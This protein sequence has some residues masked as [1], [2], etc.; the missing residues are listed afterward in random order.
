MNE[1]MKNTKDF[2][3]KVIQEDKIKTYFYPGDAEWYMGTVLDIAMLLNKYV[4]IRNPTQ[5]HINTYGELRCEK[6]GI[7]KTE[8][9]IKEE[10]ENRFFELVNKEVIVPVM[11][12]ED[13]GIMAA[14]EKLQAELNTVFDPEENLFHKKIEDSK[15][16]LD[17][18][19]F[20]INPFYRSYDD[21]MKI[22]KDLVNS[23]AKDPKFKEII[24][25]KGY[26]DPSKEKLIS[27]KT[28]HDPITIMSNRMNLDVLYAIALNSGNGG[29]A[30]ITIRNPRSDIWEYKSKTSLDHL[31]NLPNLRDIKTMRQ[32]ST[33]K[34]IFKQFKTPYE[35]SIDEIVKF[36][37][38]DAFKCV[39]KI[40]SQSYEQPEEQSE[41]E[42]EIISTITYEFDKAINKY[43]ELTESVSNKLLLLTVFGGFISLLG[44]YGIPIAAATSCGVASVIKPLVRGFRKEVVDKAM[45]MYK[46]HPYW[47]FNTYKIDTFQQF[48]SGMKRK[49][50]G[51]LNQK[52]GNN[53]SVKSNYGAASI[54][55]KCLRYPCDMEREASDN[56]PS[57]MGHN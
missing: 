16:I 1:K 26:I 13:V 4:V 47:I 8:D 21:A 53:F 32:Y 9:N 17:R 28:K 27:R 24:N 31:R 18:E 6:L 22:W 56:V 23:D 48:K 38:D 42:D 33:I 5:E 39:L 37:K 12:S 44:L 49:V 45:T 36:R 34:N 35:L 7:E 52:R 15:F 2:A 20:G 25:K 41:P 29:D 14:D 30:S 10:G 51:Y 55:Y 3:Q 57:F 50:K 11:L 54:S 19:L 43:N 46:G 40:M